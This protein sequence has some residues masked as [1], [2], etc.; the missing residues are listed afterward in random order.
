MKEKKNGPANCAAGQRTADA[1]ET[2]CKR[3]WY[4]DMVHTPCADSE[5]EDQ[6]CHN[7][8]CNN[9]GAIFCVHVTVEYTFCSFLGKGSSQIICLCA[10]AHVLAVCLS[11]CLLFHLVP[12]RG[13]AQSHVCV[14]LSI[15]VCLMVSILSS[16]CLRQVDIQHKQ[17]PR[18]LNVAWGNEPALK[19]SEL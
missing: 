17:G 1:K 14:F 8:A 12:H 10:C 2:D 9:R 3:I 16:V 4:F 7:V 19:C 13:C 15:C 5:S 11:H 6:T 18:S